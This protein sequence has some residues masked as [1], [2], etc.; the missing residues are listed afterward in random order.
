[1]DARERKTFSFL[2]LF[3]TQVTKILNY[4][5][6]IQLEIRMSIRFC[7]LE[8]THRIETCSRKI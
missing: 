8:N 5:F 4:I 3:L 6:G 1:M 7:R 2:I